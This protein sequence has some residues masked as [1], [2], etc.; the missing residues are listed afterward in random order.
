M[1]NFE[2]IM[3][4]FTYDESATA[5]TAVPS[6][7]SLFSLFFGMLA[8]KCAMYE[9]WSASIVFIAIAATLDL[10]DGKVARK[11]NVSTKFGEA[12]DSLSDICNFGIMPGLIIYIWKGE[13]MGNI[14][15]LSI[16]FYVFCC[17]IR[18]A[19]FN[20]S[21]SSDMAQSSILNKESKSFRG[22]P[23]PIGGL[24]ALLP[25]SLSVQNHGLQFFSDPRLISLHL[26]SI[27]LFMLSDIAT[28]SIKHIS[29]SSTL[30][31]SIASLLAVIF[32]FKPLLSVVLFTLS[33]LFLLLIGL[34]NKE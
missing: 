25:L 10:M 8:L 1:G 11:L 14:G 2:S 6:I 24:L 33:Y 21:I 34:K 7:M 26:I 23:A 15:W 16:V 18:L 29:V 20:A 30:F 22:M 5:M 31:K 3:R 19:R 32:I 9:N 13:E 12:M 28:P 4:S 27:G 17:T